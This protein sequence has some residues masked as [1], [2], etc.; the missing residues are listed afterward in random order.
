M[1]QAMPEQL[2]R[3]PRCH[4]HARTTGKQCR[5]PAMRGKRVCKFHGGKGGGQRGRA[6]GSFRHGGWT[7]EAVTIRREA[8]ALLKAIRKELSHV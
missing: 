5:Q 2:R 6:N 8:S 7:N 3:C 1:A 4:A